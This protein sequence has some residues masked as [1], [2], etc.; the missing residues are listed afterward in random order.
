[1]SRNM[2]SFKKVKTCL[3]IYSCSLKKRFWSSALTDDEDG[4]EL[5]LKKVGSPFSIL[6]AA[7]AEI[8]K[9]ELL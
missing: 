5:R 3:R 2:P 4:N 1:M 6:N 8:T 9:K 7:P